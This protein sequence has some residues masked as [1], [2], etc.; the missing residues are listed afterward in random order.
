M[1]K[2]E[3]LNNVSKIEEFIVDNYNNAEQ[4]RHL[5]KLNSIVEVYKNGKRS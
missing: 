4:E 2:Q 3:I 5:T 1:K